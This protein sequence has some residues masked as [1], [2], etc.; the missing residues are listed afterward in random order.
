MKTNRRKWI[1]RGLGLTAGT[2]TSNI[3]FAKDGPNKDSCPTSPRQ[4]YGPFPPMKALDQADKDAD[5]TMVTGQNGKVQGKVIN[6]KGRVMDQNCNPLEG[7]VVIIWQSNHFG[8]YHHEYDSSSAEVDPNF[9]GW[10]QTVTDN[11]GSYSFKTIYPGLYQ[12]RTRHIHFKVAKRGYH[13]I[14]TQLYFEGEER[15]NTDGLYNILTFEEQKLVT[16]KLDGSAI[17][18]I[19]FDLTIDP[20]DTKKL[21]SA[22]LAQYTGTYALD[23]LDKNVKEMLDF[24]HISLNKLEPVISQREGKLFMELPFTPKTELYWMSKD[25]FDA[26]SFGRSTIIFQRGQSEKVSSM[27]IQ[28]FDDDKLWAR[29]EKVQK[30]SENSKY[31]K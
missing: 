1:K 8:R 31:P 6:V 12:G 14:V 26:R 16:S 7:A 22:V 27:V 10:G 23:P 17:P 18:T 29:A 2:I 24:I 13:E 4:E 19:Y 3:I 11:Q 15:N 25:T 9:Q 5:L 28:S 21:P 20:I 30:P